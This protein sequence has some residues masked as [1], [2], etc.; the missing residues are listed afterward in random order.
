MI[1]GTVPN[2]TPGQMKD[3]ASALTQAIPSDM[4]SNLAQALISNKGA[5]QNAVREVLTS[6]RW[7]PKPI[8]VPA[9]QP[10]QSVVDVMVAKHNKPILERANQPKPAPVRPSGPPPK[11]TGFCKHC[12]SRIS[13]ERKCL[14]CD[15]TL[16]DQCLTCHKEVAHDII[17]DQ[18]I[19]IVGSDRGLS[20][21]DQDPDAFSR[22]D[23]D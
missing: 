18:N 10:K 13:G 11:F 20:G 21:I 17:V 23:R 2:I 19:H 15:Q 8:E 4:P 22:A 3:L 1:K 9:V 14:E 5:V 16:V 7:L 6:D 12:Q